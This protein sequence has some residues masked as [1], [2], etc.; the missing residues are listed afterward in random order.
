MTH[1][2]TWL[3]YN[4][5]IQKVMFS[6][7][8]YNI[9]YTCI[10]FTSKFFI[11]PCQGTELRVKQYPTKCKICFSSLINLCIIKRKFKYFEWIW[12][13]FQHTREIYIFF[14]SFDELKVTYS[15]KIWLS[16]IF[17]CDETVSQSIDVVST[18]FRRFAIAGINY[19]SARFLKLYLIR[20]VQLILR[21]G[22]IFWVSLTGQT[23]SAL[24]SILWHLYA[25]I[26]IIII[27]I[28]DLSIR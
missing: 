14:T 26:F 27:W 20:A 7:V 6:Q 2:K 15:P 11:L 5:Y 10:Y 9:F 24:Y 16:S 23:I 1:R 17:R 22:K 25:F 18:S 21:P 8:K 4:A 3:K 28:S 19:V 12:L 13:L